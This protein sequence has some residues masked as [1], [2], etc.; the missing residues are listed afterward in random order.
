MKQFIVACLL[1]F[2]IELNAQDRSVED[3]MRAFYKE[4]CEKKTDGKGQSLGV[5]MSFMIPCKW[6]TS[7]KRSIP[8]LVNYFDYYLSDSITFSFVLLV[9][10]AEVNM[11]NEQISKGLTQ[12]TMKSFV[13]TDAKLIMA[14]KT[15]ISNYPAAE[16]ILSQTQEMAGIKVFLNTVEYLVFYKNKV[17]TM[18]YS[19]GSTRID[20][21]SDYLPKFTILA[22]GLGGLTYLI[23][24]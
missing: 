3:S 1:F 23:D 6:A 2:A 11:T 21:V 19:I 8:N 14:T 17:I 18:T 16:L 20:K 7:L 5:T 4:L 10:K 9:D 12:E 24:K 15:K 22:K 13:P